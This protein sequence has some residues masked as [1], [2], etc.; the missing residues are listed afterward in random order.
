M[1]SETLVTMQLGETSVIGLFRERIAAAPGQTLGVSI[2]P[3]KVHL[4]DT[5]TGQRLT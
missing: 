2:D 4:F 1:G 5:E 3:A